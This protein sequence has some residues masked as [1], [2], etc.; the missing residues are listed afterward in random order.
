MNTPETI[1]GHGIYAIVK[2]H[3]IITAEEKRQAAKWMDDEQANLVFLTPAIGEIETH[4]PATG[5][6]TATASTGSQT[7]Q[8][9]GII[10][11]N[12][13]SKP[14]PGSE[15]TSIEVTYSREV[16]GRTLTLT[17]PPVCA[18]YLG[19]P[20]LSEKDSRQHEVYP[21]DHIRTLN[22]HFPTTPHK[23]Y[24]LGFSAVNEGELEAPFTRISCAVIDSI[25]HKVYERVESANSDYVLT[26]MAYTSWCNGYDASVMEADEELH[27]AYSGVLG[28]A[29]RSLNAASL[30]GVTGS[31]NDQWGSWAT[32]KDEERKLVGNSKY[33]WEMNE[34]ANRIY[35]AMLHLDKL[36]EAI[37]DIRK[38]L[39]AY[40]EAVKATPEYSDETARELFWFQLRHLIA[41][42]AF[43][44]DPTFPYPELNDR[45]WDYRVDSVGN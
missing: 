24:E 38:R 21:G 26:G 19:A 12:H 30:T 8:V 18:F 29:L 27:S 36:E 4:D 42:G 15:I 34:A 33:T 41:R 35:Y 16:N 3:P 11:P 10:N 45:P 17:D 31:G 6:F 32:A 7:L 25:G 39:Q 28:S 9:T 44:N 22:K 1:V 23:V 40:Q 43:K 2:V 14:E 37:G 20:V 5:R 13:D